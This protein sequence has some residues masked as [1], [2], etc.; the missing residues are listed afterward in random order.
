[1]REN[2]SFYRLALGLALLG[3]LVSS[4]VTATESGS[5]LGRV[6]DEIVARERA[7]AATLHQYEP[8][9]ET[10]VQTVKPGGVM[11]AEPVKD[12]Y[13]LGRLRVPAPPAVVTGK[14]KGK[15]SQ[16]KA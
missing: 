12:R 8:L 14:G 16:R 4:S 1:M 5:Q 13:F 7:L 2:R 9:V 6:L 15:K 10:Y 11:G 3:V